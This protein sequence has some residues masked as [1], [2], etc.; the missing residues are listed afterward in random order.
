MTIPETQYFI[1][2]LYSTHYMLPIAEVYV[3][4]VYEVEAILKA[5]TFAKL[6][7][8]S[9]NL[10]VI[11]DIKKTTRRMF[12]DDIESSRSY[13]ETEYAMLDRC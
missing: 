3:A 4:N 5:K 1:V 11:L 6:Y 12:E 9:H 10:Q 8:R 2:E 7:A 13:Y